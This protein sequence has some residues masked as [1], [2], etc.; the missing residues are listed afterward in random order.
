MTDGE[1]KFHHLSFYKIV[2]IYKSSIKNTKPTKKRQEET[3][4]RAVIPFNVQQ[5][6]SSYFRWYRSVFW[7]FSFAFYIGRRPDGF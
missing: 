7:S 2:E 6:C 3:R 4:A 1:V 5:T